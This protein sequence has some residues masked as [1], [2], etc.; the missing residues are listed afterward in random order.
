MVVDALQRCQP[1]GL[2]AVAMPGSILNSTG[3][4]FSQTGLD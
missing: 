3:D 2:P 1:W 4:R